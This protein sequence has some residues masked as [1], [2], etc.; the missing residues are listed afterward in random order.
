VG[1]RHSD[2]RWIA[3]RGQCWFDERGEPTRFVGTAVDVSDRKRAAEQLARSA[4]R[5]QQ[6]YA[7]AKEAERRKDEFLAML[8]H[9][10]RNP[11]APIHTTLQL[12]RLRGETALMRERTIIERQTLHL[13]RL[14]SDLL[15]VSRIT[16]GKIQL[17]R[18]RMEVSEIVAK[19]IELTAP[20]LEQKKHRL[21]IEVPSRGMIVE[22]DHVRLTQVMTNLLTNAAKYSEPGSEVRVTATRSAGGVVLRVKDTGAGISP[23]LVPHIFDLFTQ[24]PQTLA[25]SEGG[26]GLGLTIAKSLVEMHGGQIHASSEG[27]GRGSEFVVA[28]PRADTAAPAHPQTDD[29]SLAADRRGA[30]GARVLVVDDNRD[31]AETLAEALAHEG[32]EV[33]VAYDG[34][35]ALELAARCGPEIVLLDI[36]LPV[37]DGYEVA[38]RLRKA[39][40]R[41]PLKLI[42]VTGYGQENDRAKAA[43]AGFD[44]HVVKPVD[45]DLLLEALQDRHTP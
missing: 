10:L 25:R 6:A 38:R 43:E 23:E 12:L 32:H 17:Q 27:P 14:V 41:A 15:D 2:C 20:L 26:L 40:A 34:A 22:G 21:V 28:L 29:V 9:E 16:R 13:E 19:A 44:A 35:S 1:L 8:G 33:A 11:L 37:L 30:H 31:A 18:E 5:A 24:A 4:E 42:A 39:Q 3:A 36:G 7:A 45:L